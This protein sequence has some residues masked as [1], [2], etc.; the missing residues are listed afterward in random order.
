[1]I[2]HRLA[3]QA[4][5]AYHQSKSLKT[6]QV[7]TSMVLSQLN[8]HGFRLR[9]VQMQSSRW[10]LRSISFSIINI[11]QLSYQLRSLSQHQVHQQGKT[12]LSHN[13]LNPVHVPHWLANNPT[14]WNICVSIIGRADIEGSKRNVSM[15]ARL[16][17]ASYPGGNFSDT[18]N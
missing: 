14:L 10:C 7:A 8:Q 12:N 16:P 5:F 6:S 2:T 17:H 1:M 18:S 15:N 3:Y 4:Q 11:Y 13:G 9:G